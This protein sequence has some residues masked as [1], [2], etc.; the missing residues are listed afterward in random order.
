MIIAKYKNKSGEEDLKTS[1]IIG[2]LLHLQ[3]STIWHILRKSCTDTDNLPLSS[4]EV[5]S[6][7]FWP[8]WNAKGKGTRNE[9]RVEPDV[10]IRF[11]KFDLIIEVKRND[12][13]GQ[14]KGQ[15]SD[16]IICCKNKYERDKQPLIFIALGGNHYLSTELIQ[17]IN[18][19][20]CTWMSLC[21]SVYEENKNNIQPFE[22]RILHD[23]TVAFN[24]F[25]IY[26]VKWFSE[27]VD[28]YNI[29]NESI[30]IIKQWIELK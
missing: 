24:N 7:D 3:G 2:T 25:G 9:N 17:G 16:Q 15:W 4:G 26:D 11:E 19:Y 20:K 5:V 6:N 12:Y 10:F 22:K 1:S 21:K 8:S 18:I 27:I 30:N 23:T 13:T 28:K 14:E 29:D